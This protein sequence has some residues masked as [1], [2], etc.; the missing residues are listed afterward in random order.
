MDTT[1]LGYILN[2]QDRILELLLEQ[3]HQLLTHGETLGR[4]ISLTEAKEGAATAMAETTSQSRFSRW[5]KLEPLSRM[6]VGGVVSWIVGVIIN[7]HLANGGDP[8]AL[9]DLLLKFLF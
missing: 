3:H 5:L 6:I 8:T 2:K 9:L 1:I 4:I 7:R